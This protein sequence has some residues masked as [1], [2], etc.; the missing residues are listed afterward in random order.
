MNTVD[1][2]TGKVLFISGRPM[3][4]DSAP[5]RRLAQPPGATSAGNGEVFTVPAPVSWTAP[6]VTSGDSFQLKVQ[7]T[8]VLTA[9]DKATALSSPWSPPLDFTVLSNDPA[10]APAISS[11]DYPSG[12]WGQPQGAPGVFT[13]G[14]NGDTSIAGFEYA[15][16]NQSVAAPAATDCNYNNDGGLGTSVNSGGG[17]NSSGELALVRGGTQQIQAPLNLS[18]GRHTLYVLA[19]DYAHNPS[20]IASYTFYVA[21]NYS[22]E[23]T[24]YVDGS[25]LVSQATGTNASLVVSQANCCGMTW[26][27]GSQLRF[28]GTASGQT[29]TVPVAVPGAGTW[30]LGAEMTLSFNYGDVQ[31]DLDKSTSDINLAGTATVPFDG[32]SATVSGTYLDLG[33]QTLT[34]GTHTL[35]FTVTGKDSSSQGY[36]LGVVYLTLSPTNRYE[37]DTLTLPGATSPSWT[38]TNTPSTTTIRQQCLNESTWSDHCEVLFQNATVPNPPGTPAGGFTMTFVA[39]ISSDY[40]LGV[41]LGISFDFGELEFELDPSSSDIILDNSQAAPI[42]TDSSVIS[43]KYVFLGG[44]YLSAGLHVLR[45][46]VVNTTTTTGNEY[47]AGINF[48]TVIPVTGALDKTFTDAMNNQG[49]ATDGGSD[50]AGNFDLTNTAT[51]GNLSLNALEA[52]GITPGTGPTFSLNGAAFTMPPLRTDGW[53]GGGLVRPMARCTRPRRFSCTA[54]TLRFSLAGLWGRISSAS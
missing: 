52:A 36:E 26:A 53:A 41:N 47:N 19:F 12:Y 25:S 28:A 7:T 31:V 27:S 23:Q 21:P 34:A 22:G 50:L 42:N 51:G 3:M 54:A 43:S 49:I 37:A 38:G 32:Y 13:I 2:A 44:V 15:F 33:T 39:P 45:V 11:F 24:T 17:G 6:S 14:A 4:W 10:N 30:Q 18:P 8:N 16:D 9:N 20:P 40:A 46:S 1:A 5:A 35:T 48:L 29:F